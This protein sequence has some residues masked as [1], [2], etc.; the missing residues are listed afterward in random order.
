MLFNAPHRDFLEALSNVQGS[1]HL[2][3]ATNVYAASLEAVD[4]SGENVPSEVGQRLLD[5]LLGQ[6][7]LTGD[8]VVPFVCAGLIDRI[9]AHPRNDP[10]WETLI[11]QDGRGLAEIEP[12]SDTWIYR[13]V[14]HV[15]LIALVKGVDQGLV[16]LID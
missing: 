8:I 13:F 16:R 9:G 15:N 14:S 7:R 1:D 6:F 4:E 2:I 12:R 11:D 10:T 5:Y 3:A